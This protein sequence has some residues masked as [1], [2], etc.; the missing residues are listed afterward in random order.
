MNK[1]ITERSLEA[2]AL[3]EYVKK[4]EVLDYLY[5][6]SGELEETIEAM[7]KD[8]DETVERGLDEIADQMCRT[9]NALERERLDLEIQLHKLEIELAEFEKVR[10][11]T[12]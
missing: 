10:L 12:K 9:R 1:Y 11:L 3:A 7:D 4:A 6:R 2:D 8:I 5:H